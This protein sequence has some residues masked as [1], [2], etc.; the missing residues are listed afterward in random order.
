[1]KAGRN[2]TQEAIDKIRLELVRSPGQS[3]DKLMSRT[4]TGIPEFQA[5][6]RALG[7]SCR[8]MGEGKYQRTLIWSLPKKST[9][10]DRINVMTAAPYFEP[11][12]CAP[13]AGSLSYKSI[14]SRGIPT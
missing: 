9:E 12:S 14:Q 1:M 11:V 6:Q 5:A 4:G 7:L 3:R 8:K 13:R 2:F 10:R